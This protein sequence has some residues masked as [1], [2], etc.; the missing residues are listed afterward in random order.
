MDYSS[1]MEDSPVDGSLL[2]SLGVG[3]RLDVSGLTSELQSVI[4]SQQRDV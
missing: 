1:K 3:E 2:V 4:A